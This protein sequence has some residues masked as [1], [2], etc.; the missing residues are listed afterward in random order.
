MWPPRV[1]LRRGRVSCRRLVFLGEVVEVGHSQGPPRSEV[2]APLPNPFANASAVFE[3]VSDPPRGAVS[4]SLVMLAQQFEQG[5][6]GEEVD[7]VD[8]RLALVFLA[9]VDVRHSVFVAL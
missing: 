7:D 1:V 6:V 2:L 3:G 9:G 8:D 5:S 4:Q